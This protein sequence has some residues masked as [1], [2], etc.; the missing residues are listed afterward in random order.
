M[1]NASGHSTAFN[2]GIVIDMDRRWQCNS[3]GRLHVTKASTEGVQVPL[4]QC[5]GLAG[6]WVPFVPAGSEAILRVEE[7][8]DYVGK[9]TPFM[10]ANGRPIMAVYTQREDGE[11]CHILAPTVNMNIQAS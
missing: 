1:S 7:R 3:C 2:A 6:T 10:D 9:D 11:D 5:A 8:Q 4:H